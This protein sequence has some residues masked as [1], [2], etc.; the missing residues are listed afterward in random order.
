MTTAARI[1]DGLRRAIEVLR[2][3]GPYA[4]IEIV[5]PG[6]SFILLLLWLY[7]RHRGILGVSVPAQARAWNQR[8]LSTSLPYTKNPHMAATTSQ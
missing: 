7:R 1:R 8:G 3:L 4:A 6:G 5:L 2:D